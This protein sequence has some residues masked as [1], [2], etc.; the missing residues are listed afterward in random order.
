PPL[1]RAQA[2]VVQGPRPGRRAL[3]RAQ[4][5]DRRAGAQHGLRGGGVPQHRRVLGAR[6][7]HLHD[8]RRH[9]HPPLRLLQRAD[10]QAD[11]QRSARAASCRPVGQ[12]DGAPPRRGHQRRPRRPAR[13]RLARVRGDDPL[14]PKALARH[15]GRGADARLSRPGDAAG[16]GDRRAPRRV[17]PQRRD[18]AAPL[19]AGPPRLEVPALLPRP[20]QRQ[21]DGRRRGGH[22]VGADDR[23]R[24]DDGGARR[25]LR[26]TARARRPGPH[27]GPVPAPDREPPAGR[28]LLAP[29]R[30]RR[31]RAQGLR[32]G[33]RVGGR[34]SA[35]ALELS[36]RADPRAGGGAL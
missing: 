3:P 24:G 28:A 36:R 7:R 10:R 30:V 1:P 32:A 26:G 22:E 25:D 15:Q 6:H 8:P 17:Q 14:D 13:P 18:R 31:A 33:V 20:S 16:P 5:N 27:R 29:R 23:P 35:R 11:P 34:R 12:E 4:A 9:L 21:A 2:A 19:P